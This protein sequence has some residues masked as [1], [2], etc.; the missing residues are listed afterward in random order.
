[1]VLNHWYVFYPDI[2]R[3]EDKIV[4]IVLTEPYFF[5]RCLRHE[6]EV[7]QAHWT[8]SIIIWFVSSNSVVLKWPISMNLMRNVTRYSMQINGKVVLAQSN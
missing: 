5:P 2:N 8:I 4:I 1:M 6:H 7:K 3:L